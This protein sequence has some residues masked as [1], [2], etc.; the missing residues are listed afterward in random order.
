MP[1]EFTILI[2][3]ETCEQMASPWLFQSFTQKKHVVQSFMKIMKPDQPRRTPTNSDILTPKLYD[4]QHKQPDFPRKIQGET[5]AK[6]LKMTII[7]INVM[8]KQ[9]ISIGFLRLQCHF[10]RRLFWYYLESNQ[11]GW[12]PTNSDELRRTPTNSGQLSWFPVFTGSV[13]GILRLCP[14]KSH[15][16]LKLVVFQRAPQQTHEK[17]EKQ[18][19]SL[20]IW[21]YS[22]AMFESLEMGSNDAQT[23]LKQRSNDAET[24]PGAV[25]VRSHPSL[26]NL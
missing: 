7:S 17:I 8:K 19:H 1:L 18:A 2:T 16:E 9:R 12:N 15:F 20:L 24:G 22:N 26:H 11:P 3:T 4:V 14:P 6:P 10:S 21:I 5:S 13:A 23:T 25:K